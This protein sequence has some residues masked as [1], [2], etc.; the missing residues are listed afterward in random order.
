LSTIQKIVDAILYFHHKRI[1]HELRK[2][3]QRF[4]RTG[5]SVLEVG[6]GT[7][8]SRALFSRANY[9]CTDIARYQGV[10]GLCDV[11]NMPY[12]DASFD[13]VICNNLLEHLSEPWKA[14]DEMHRC[15]KHGGVCFS[16]VPFLFPLHDVPHDFFRFTEYALANLFRNWSSV[17]IKKVNLLPCGRINLIGRFVLYYVTVVQK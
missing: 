2:V 1:A 8:P 9:V 15:L 13:L 14:A 11:S 6:A 16:V 5:A 10:D 4:D 3:S 7:K 17:D 12:R